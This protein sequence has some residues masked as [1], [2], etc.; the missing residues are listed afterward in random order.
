MKL[1]VRHP[2]HIDAGGFFVLEK[3]KNVLKSCIYF[4]ISNSGSHK[5]NFVKYLYKIDHENF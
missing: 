3:G 5:Y 2:I 4:Q 1:A